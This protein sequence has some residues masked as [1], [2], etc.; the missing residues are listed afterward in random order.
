MWSGRSW[1]GLGHEVLKTLARL[2][3]F[4]FLIGG[5]DTGIERSFFGSGPP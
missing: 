3:Y 1:E 2:C 4:S 5:R